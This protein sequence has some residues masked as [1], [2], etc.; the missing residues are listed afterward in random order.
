MT[1]KALGKVLY[2]DVHDIWSDEAREFTPW[3]GSPDGLDLLSDRIGVSLESP[4]K[5]AKVGPFSADLVCRERGD[6]EHI[7]VVENQ[8]G[9][10]NHDHLGKILTYASG[11]GATTIVWI[12]ED[13]TD[14]HRQALDWLNTN[15]GESL[16]FFGLELFFIR[17]GDSPPAPQLRVVSSPNVWAQA[18]REST[19][20][21]NVSRTKLEQQAFWEEMRDCMRAKGSTLSPRKPLPQHWYE[22]AIGRANFNISFTINTD[23]SRIGCELWMSGEKA[24]QAFSQLETDRQ[25]IEAEFGEGLEWQPLEG[26]KG[27]RIAVYREDS[28]YD[29]AQREE[30]K[31][32]F[33]DMAERFHRVFAQR[34]RGLRLD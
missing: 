17:I 12:A 33:Y 14:E 13:F 16:R 18:A 24:K 28:I 7:V 34:V 21:R 9:K 2:V 22:M 25:R 32:W 11:L 19:E 10:T 27:C 31:A 3:L 8:F 6:E 23:L 5:E 20:E 30:A 29:E 1:P 4:E 15:S 26:K